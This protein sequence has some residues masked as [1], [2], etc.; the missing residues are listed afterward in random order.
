MKKWATASTPF[1]YA[2][3]DYPEL[4]EVLEEKPPPHIAEVT[5]PAPKKNLSLFGSKKAAAATMSQ[6]NDDPLD[7]GDT[8]LDDMNAGTVGDAT[9]W[10]Q[11]EDPDSHELSSTTFEGSLV[12]ASWYDIVE[13][14]K[15]IRSTG[16]VRIIAVND[17]GIAGHVQGDDGVYETELQFVPG[18]KQIGL[19]QCSCPWAAYSW[20]RSGPWKKYEGR[21]CS[22]A[23]ALDYQAQ[24]EG[25]FGRE[26][27]EQPSAPTWDTGDITR[28]QPPPQKDWRVGRLFDPVSI[29]EDLAYPY[30]A[31]PELTSES[32]LLSPSPGVEA[33]DLVDL[34]NG[35]LP[36]ISSI[37]ASPSVLSS[38]RNHVPHVVG[39]GSGDQMGNEVD[40]DGAMTR[41]A[42]LQFSR[43]LDEVGIGPSVS[44]DHSLSIP[45]LTVSSS[46][47][48]GSPVPAFVIRPS[49]DLG[50]EPLFDRETHSGYS[51]NWRTASAKVN[52]QDWGEEGNHTHG[53][54]EEEGTIPTSYIAN[55][56]GKMDEV[57][58]E[59]RNRHGQQW[60][61]FKADIAKNG[62]HDPIFITVDWN[63]RPYIS[64]GNHRR[65]AAVELGMEE[66]PVTV[67][68]FGCAEKQGRV[69][70]GRTGYSFSKAASIANDVE[71]LYATG[72]P[73]E[74]LAREYAITPKPEEF[75]GHDMEV[76]SAEYRDLQ[77]L[78]P[79]VEDLWIQLGLLCEDGMDQLKRAGW[80]IRVQFE[81]PY[82]TAAE[83]HADLAQKIYKVTTQ[84][85]HHPVWDVDT[86]VAFRVC[87]DIL[88]HGE[89]HSDFS[90]MGEVL[91][92][93]SQCRYI[94]E[95]L[96]PVLF[97]EVV[98]Q[99]AYANVHHLFGEQKVG[100]INYTLDQIE[101]LI[102]KITDAPDPDYDRLHY[103][104]VFQG[105]YGWWLAPD[106]TLIEVVDAMSHFSTEHPTGSIHLGNELWGI[107]GDKVSL[108]SAGVY[109]AI[110]PEQM[111]SLYKL[112]YSR[113][114]KRFAG[115]VFGPDGESLPGF[116]GISASM[117]NLSKQEIIDKIRELGQIASRQSSLDTLFVQIL[118]AEHDVSEE[119]RADD[120]KW[121]DGGPH[122]EHDPQR[123]VP[124]K[125]D[126]KTK[127]IAADLRMHDIP[128]EK[129][130]A[131]EGTFKKGIGI[132]QREALHNLV[133]MYERVPQDERDESAQWYHVAHNE[134]LT[135]ATNFDLDPHVV[136]GVVAATSPG[137][138]WEMNKKFARAICEA[139]SHADEPVPAEHIE[140]VNKMLSA[141]RK[142][143][144][145]GEETTHDPLTDYQIPKGATYHQ[146]FAE[147]TRAGAILIG[148]KGHLSCGYGY[149]NIEKGLKIA[150]GKKEDIADLLAGAK[151]RSFYN[152]LENPD[153][154][155]D[156]CI[157]SHMWRTFVNDPD[158]PEG[159]VDERLKNIDSKMSMITSSP[160]I[161]GAQVGAY[162]IGAD[163]LHMAT[164]AINAKHGTHYV[165]SQ[166]QAILWI[167]QR[168]EYGIGDIRKAVNGSVDD[169]KPDRIP[170]YMGE[171]PEP[172]QEWFYVDG[173][174]VQNTEDV[175]LK[176]LDAAFVSVL[177]SMV[178][179]SYEGS[180]CMIALRPPDEICKALVLDDPDAEPFEELHYT[181]VYIKDM[182]STDMDKLREIVLAESILYPSLKGKIQGYG[183]FHNGDEDVLW[184]GL[185][186]NDVYLFRA[187]LCEALDRNGIAYSNDHEFAP[188]MTLKYVDGPI[189]TLPPFPASAQ[190]EFAFTELIIGTANEWEFYGLGGLKVD[191]VREHASELQVHAVES[192][193]LPFNDEDEETNGVGTDGYDQ[194]SQG[195]T[196]AIL[197]DEP[198]PA[199]PSTE[200]GEEEEAQGLPMEASRSWLMDRP[201][202]AGG[203]VDIAA[204]AREFLQK[205]A[206]KDFTFAE[207]QELI[208]E[209]E[210][211]RTSNFDSL[212]LAGTHYLGLEAALLEAEERDENVLWW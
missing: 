182:A 180:G 119:P 20:G 208:N 89:V 79:D 49:V 30:V 98:A 115:S 43:V 67:R 41:M 151:V 99:S 140:L 12:S 123:I 82:Q 10:S 5:T 163:L 158:Q 143:K 150:L 94:P 187:L 181:L 16:G 144:H 36:T 59:H 85:S 212:D 3:E 84:H 172:E 161:A 45:E 136:L 138:Q 210:N 55:M 171:N 142:I 18:S 207:Q 189:T 167:H 90:F 37:Q 175:P 42:D 33:A 32:R 64:E 122:K 203:D 156:V 17:Q 201:S 92:Y 170:T 118:A 173:K 61:D 141:K 4:Q 101:A 72:R 127:S 195:Q 46:S 169:F 176:S 19:W 191:D 65:D 88:G 209:G 74:E 87:H 199:L 155:K 78:D 14:A 184:A 48:G 121:T 125:G 131:V 132:D 38:R 28:Y 137:A 185:T 200:G 22:H 124:L 34:L 105:P 100:L 192:D 145:D 186:S 86:N 183:Q 107:S 62:I 93:R 205:S 52:W 76:I 206:V 174:W 177:C 153:S 149:G 73:S 146:V 110:T 51:T 27:V 77:V 128:Q 109:G 95:N 117:E 202:G 44:A 106:G 126:A 196:E 50:P 63:D 97:T 198:E 102:G 56:P 104:A 81:D 11:D 1:H 60:E 57:P 130:K 68:Y 165:P 66:V 24:S 114:F 188:H 58:G 69:S 148:K 139:V 25:F 135:E 160:A 211:V 7:M 83:M 120:G 108:L 47:Q 194:V 23:L 91:A 112:V 166:V 53:T 9:D 178:K 21:M 147:N 2:S 15:R 152:N 164:A 71:P 159:V 26:V 154:D 8:G 103:S 70:E 29:A 111:K 113:D 75:A 6:P 204:G 80:D 134:A 197:L 157:D 13:K 162:P 133:S 54:M 129:R 179:T 39:M 31:N 190:G 40:A 168:K 116:P 193:P 35:E 96:W